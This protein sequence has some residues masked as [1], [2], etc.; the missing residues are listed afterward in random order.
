M[1]PCLLIKMNN[2]NN[3]SVDYKNK[4]KNRV[5]QFVTFSSLMAA[6]LACLGAMLLL[7]SHGNTNPG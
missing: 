3:E 4:T 6:S 1:K 7:T 5:T 2:N